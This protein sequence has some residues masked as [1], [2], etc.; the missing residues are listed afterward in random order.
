MISAWTVT[1]R[2]VVGSSATSTSGPAAMAQAIIT[3]WRM[4]PDSWLGCCFSTISGRRMRTTSRSSLA[5]A[6]MLPAFAS[7]LCAIASASCAP[8]VITGL[9]PASALCGT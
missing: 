3:R 2:P 6:G 5:R 1:S 7:G 8:T 9:R 4:P